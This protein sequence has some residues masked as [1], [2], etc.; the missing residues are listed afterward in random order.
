M[1]RH[2]I[3]YMLLLAAAYDLWWNKEDEDKDMT[4][5]SCG[6]VSTTVST[7]ETVDTESTVPNAEDATG[8]TVSLS[9]ASDCHLTEDSNALSVKADD[10]IID[11]TWADNLQVYILMY[12]EVVHS[13]L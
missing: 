12:C 6:A 1:S 13:L 10:G 3:L 11:S 2:I 8:N 9:L 4:G 5:A 7:E